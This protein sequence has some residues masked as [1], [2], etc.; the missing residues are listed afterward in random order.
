[1]P[2]LPSLPE[3]AHL[4]DLFRRFPNGVEPL[5]RYTDD[6]LRGKGALDV[7]D[8]ELIAT[9]VSGLNGCDFCF[10]SHLV[11]AELFGIEPGLIRALLDDL[12]SA[13]VSEPMRALLIYVKKLNTLPSRLVQADARA[14]LEAGNSEDALFEAVQICGLF[15]MMNRIVEGAGVD[16]DYGANPEAHPAHQ[17]TPEAHVSSYAAFGAKLAALTAKD[18]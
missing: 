18:G 1:M 6:V 3:N 14:V 13:P 10:D 9:F 7:A 11:Y 16:F 8:R 17:S 2:H 5:M 15:N 12:D 4:S